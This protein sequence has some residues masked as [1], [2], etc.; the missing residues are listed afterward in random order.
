MTTCL[1]YCR[2]INQQLRLLRRQNKKSQYFVF[3]VY[4]SLFF[5]NLPILAKVTKCF[6]LCSS[7]FCEILSYNQTYLSTFAL[8][9][10]PICSLICR[11]FTNAHYEISW[12]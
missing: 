9:P 6:D 10:K 3:P 12:D 4:F 2:L 7:A 5:F 11:M 1:M 8:H